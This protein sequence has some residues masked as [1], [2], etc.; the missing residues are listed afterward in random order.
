MPK[1][2]I[3]VPIYN[4]EIHLS[5]CIDSI[6]AQTYTDFELILIN[7]GSNDKSREICDYYATKDRRIIVVHK[8]NGG[9]S[10]ARNRGLNVANGERQPRLDQHCKHSK[11]P[12]LPRP[13]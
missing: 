2:S 3:I 12:L 10:S 8:E 7:D 9:T 13:R 4:S 11:D 6:L 1:V 5:R